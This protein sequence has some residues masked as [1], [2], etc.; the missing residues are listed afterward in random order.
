MKPLVYDAEGGLRGDSL[1]RGLG[2]FLYK[3]LYNHHYMWPLGVLLLVAGS[4][5]AL[6]GYIPWSRKPLTRSAQILGVL[7]TCASV[8]FTLPVFLMAPESEMRLLGWGVLVSALTVVGLLF[9]VT[10]ALPALLRDRPRAPAFVGLLLCLS[11][12]PVSLL[13]MGLAHAVL[14]FR[15]AA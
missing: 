11:P 5:M 1:T 13:L 12:L 4:G 3:S 15:L 10:T 6:R 9:A 7:V 2:I 8:F 14:G